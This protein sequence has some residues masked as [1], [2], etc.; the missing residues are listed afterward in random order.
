VC[1]T[2]RKLGSVLIWR[3]A[4]IVPNLQRLDG[5][6]MLRVGTTRAPLASLKF[7]SGHHRKLRFQETL[8]LRLKH[9]YVV[10]G[11]FVELR[12]DIRA[13]FLDFE[14]GAVRGKPGAANL[15]AV[16]AANADAN[17]VERDQFGKQALA[18][19][20]KGFYGTCC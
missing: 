17:V 2:G 8:L 20:Q 18:A 3:G 4:R 11:Q 13:L 15:H 12:G 5:A 19:N 10:V 7:K 9:H 16:A 1:G 14:S 6:D